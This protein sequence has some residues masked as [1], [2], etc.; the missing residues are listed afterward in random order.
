[1]DTIVD[2]DA[3]RAH[4]AAWRRAG[5][6]IGFAPTMGNLHD[7]HFSLVDIARSNCD[8]IVASV[9]VNP[10]QFGPNED[11][12][13][14]PRTLEQDQAGLQAHACDV[15]F[16]PEVQTMYPF[17]S[18]DCVRVEVPG[19][20]D[21][22]DGASRPGH[23]TGV[24]TVVTRLFNL[25]QPDLAVFGQKDYQ[26]L[27]VIRRL[28]ADL[29]MPIE[30]VGAPIVREANGLAMSSRNQYLT[31]E[32]RARSGIIHRTLLTMRDGVRSGE[33]INA[34]EAT[35][36]NALREAGL[37]PDYAVLR[38]ARDLSVPAQQTRTGLVALIAATIGRARL[39]DNLLVD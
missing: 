11:F 15:L 1:M 10:T 9:F 23:F 19:L 37:V 12:A 17:G 30:I 24:A 35:A 2:V 26:Q 33:S 31:T 3:L 6:R 18:T 13:T 38:D 39:I 16:A 25:V 4:I 21:I 22:L 28:A 14:Y 27:L 8:R 29:Q 5:L 34:I 36:Q 20:S 32:E 7:G